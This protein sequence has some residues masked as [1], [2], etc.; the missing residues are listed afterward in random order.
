MIPPLHGLHLS[1]WLPATFSG[2]IT[3]ARRIWN[4]SNFVSGRLRSRYPFRIKATV[5]ELQWTW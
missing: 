1:R 2:A 5:D 4:M 3:R